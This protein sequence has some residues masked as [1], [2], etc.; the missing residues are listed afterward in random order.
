M[1][2]QK[3]QNKILLENITNALYPPSERDLQYSFYSKFAWGEEK[4][5]EW[6]EVN[7]N[8]CGT[9]VVLYSDVGI[10]HYNYHIV[11]TKNGRTLWEGEDH[12]FVQED[13]GLANYREE[14]IDEKLE[15]W[16]DFL[17]AVTRYKA[18]IDVDLEDDFWRLVKYYIPEQLLEINKSL[19]DFLSI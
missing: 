19:N 11:N 3:I 4:E 12:A 6:Y 15:Y 10:Y 1:D 2:K 16:M 8:N 18:Y 13:M 5:H 9:V 14:V 7:K 17:Q